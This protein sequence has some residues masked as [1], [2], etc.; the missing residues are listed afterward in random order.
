MFCTGI[1][2]YF[3]LINLNTYMGIFQHWE[4]FGYPRSTGFSWSVPDQ[5]GFSIEWFPGDQTTVFNLGP[6]VFSQYNILE[7]FNI[8]RKALNVQGVLASHGQHQ[9]CRTINSQ[10]RCDQNDNSCAVCQSSIQIAFQ[11]RYRVYQYYRGM[12]Y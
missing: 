10:Q 12:Q 6:P 5:C 7:Y 9:F 2:Y 4:T 11:Q 1:N 3:R 8:I